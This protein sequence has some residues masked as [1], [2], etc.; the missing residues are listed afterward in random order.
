MEKIMDAL[1]KKL[2]TIGVRVVGSFPM[3]ELEYPTISV[4]LANGNSG[5]TNKILNILKD[6]TTATL[7]NVFTYYNLLFQIDVFA[8]TSRERDQLISKVISKLKEFRHPS[9]EEPLYFV[10]IQSMRNLD[11]EYE[12]RTSI[13]ARMYGFEVMQSFEYLVKETHDEIIKEV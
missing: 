11:N 9:Y 2:K 12:Y 3:S 6:E 8:K 1:L 4:T 5:N 10:R 13:D 7:D